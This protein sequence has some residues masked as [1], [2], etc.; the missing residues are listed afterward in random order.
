MDTFRLCLGFFLMFLSVSCGVV[1][2][3]YGIQIARLRHEMVM[4]KRHGSLALLVISLEVWALLISLPFS[5]M[6][7]FNWSLAPEEGTSTYR[8]MKMIEDFIYLP[9]GYFAIIL[10][11]LRLWLMFFDIQLASSQSKLV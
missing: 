9:P 3:Y 11:F 7:D 10:S 4:V 1:L 6:A 8:I 2:I 5:L